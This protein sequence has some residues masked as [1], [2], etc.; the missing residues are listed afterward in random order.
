M[1]KLKQINLKENL[2]LVQQEEVVVQETQGGVHLSKEEITREKTKKLVMIGTVIAEG[3]LSDEILTA[4]SSKGKKLTTLVGQVI[5]YHKMSIDV[6][7]IPV[8]NHNNL[9]TV[10]GHYPIAIISDE[11]N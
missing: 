1:L 9:F 4:L 5:A 10:N 6:F 2:L 3:N 7:D 11:E 8:E